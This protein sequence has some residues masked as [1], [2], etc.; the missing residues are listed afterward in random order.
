MKKYKTPRPIRIGN[1]KLGKQTKSGF[2]SKWLLLL[3]TLVAMVALS[4]G[5]K[6][7]FTQGNLVVLQ[8]G[9][10]ET[11]SLNGNVVVLNEYTKTGASKNTIVIPSTGSSSL[12]QL[13]LS[14]SEGA[15]SLSADG[16][17]AIIAGYNTALNTYTDATTRIDGSTGS[18]APRGIGQ[19]DG[20][21]A[22]SLK[23]SSSTILSG[24]AFKSA[25]SDGNGNYWGGGNATT[26]AGLAY[27]GNNNSAIAGVSTTGA[28]SDRVVTFINGNLYYGTGA[29]GVYEVGPIGST[30]LT[31]AGSNATVTLKN[32]LGNHFKD[33]YGFAINPSET[34]AYAADNTSGIAMF[35]SSGGVWTYQYTFLNT[36]KT[37]SVSGAPSVGS[38]G[39]HGIAVDFT[40]TPATIYYTTPT[41]LYS[42]QDPGNGTDATTITTLATAPTGTV[43]RG[44]AWAPN[45]QLVSQL[46]GGIANATLTANSS[47]QALYGFEVNSSGVGTISTI[48]FNASNISSSNFVNWYLYSSTSSSYAA[49]TS[50]LIAST[51]AGTITVGASSITATIPS[52]NQ[53]LAQGDNYYFLVA[54]VSSSVTNASAPATIYLGTSGITGTGNFGVLNSSF[55]AGTLPTVNYAFAKALPLDWE[56]LIVTSGGN[57]TA[58]LNWVTTKEYNTNYFEVERS[59]DEVNFKKLGIVRNKVTTANEKYSFTD[60]SIVQGLIYY[61]IKQVDKNGNFTYSKV[62]AYNAKAQTSFKLYPNPTTNLLYIQLPVEATEIK[63]VDLKGQVLMMR[64]VRNLTATTLD[65]S[66]LTIGT[67]FLET[68]TNA[69][70]QNIRFIKK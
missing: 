59:E 33:G 50:T 30:A 56:S 12:I 43:F 42:V 26:P 7:Q 9:N 69:G 64:N 70:K 29:S 19:I 28:T 47:G 2:L 25:A 15:I 22:Y 67:Y 41:G 60:S 8:Q 52:A 14:S 16:R 66:Q 39:P 34:V 45:A 24:Y 35:T 65:V 61:R 27:F 18:I 31:T 63:I 5:V 11:L 13:G 32:D 44:L 57:N 4:V 10:G 54:D 48:S 36:G 53:T 23:A 55:G 1:G 37:S 49:A 20:S 3:L 62:V 21:G 46:T 51:A 38:A 40:T 58:V 68:I 17:Y 6:A